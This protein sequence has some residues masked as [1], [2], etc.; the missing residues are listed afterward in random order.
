MA[1][2][3]LRSPAAR[4][5]SADRTEA[6]SVHKSFRY[7]IKNILPTVKKSSDSVLIRNRRC[8]TVRTEQG[9]KRIAF[10]RRER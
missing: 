1:K 2:F 5:T 10:L 6:P 9:E 4:I 8:P 7:S 3:R